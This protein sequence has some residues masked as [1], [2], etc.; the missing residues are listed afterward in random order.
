M[1]QIAIVA[2][3][4]PAP[5]RALRSCIAKGPPFD[6]GA[7]GITRHSV[8]LAAD[9]VVFVFEGHEVESAVDG[10]IEDP[11]PVDG[12]R[13]VRRVAPSRGRRPEDRAP[14]SCVG[15]IRR[16]GRAVGSACGDRR[17]RTAAE[18]KPLPASEL[19]LIDRVLARGELPLG[20][21]NLPAR[22]P[23]PAGATRRRA[24]EAAPPRPLRDDAG[25]EPDLRPSQ[26]RDPGA[27]PERAL[28]HGH[29]VTEARA[30]SRTRTSKARTPRST[31]M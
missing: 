26:P 13:G 8:Y 17:E 27:G 19:K 12:E 10:L 2:R 1:E 16:A 4:K 5:S 14:C 29:R 23:A 6:P 21:S 24:R 25:A 7:V 28:R 30:S 20:R 15:V 31:H 22:Q 11:A 3:L 18:T 9:A